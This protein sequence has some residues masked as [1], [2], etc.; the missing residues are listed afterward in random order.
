MRRAPSPLVDRFRASRAARGAR[1]RV[2]VLAGAVAL[3][4]A[5]AAC[6]EDD[7]SANALPPPDPAASHVGA[8]VPPPPVIASLPAASTVA[9][10]A[11]PASSRGEAAG[12]DAKSSFDPRRLDSVRA[13][14]D[15]AL[16]RGA[17][18]SAD[19]ECRTVAVGGKACGG[20]TGYRAYSSQG[21][22]PKTVE[23]LAADERQL[24]LQQ[25]RAEGRVSPCFMLAD[26]GAHCEAHKCVTGPAGGLPGNG[27]LVPEPPSAHAS[28]VR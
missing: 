27:R 19:A 4:A 11:A 17:S 25:A 5:L 21:A 28:A 13:N 1:R 6:R 20:P 23:S 16:A 8:P 3:A 2:A 22:D 12:V 26:P 7:A 18:C 10:A 15:A 9:D 24:S 14:L